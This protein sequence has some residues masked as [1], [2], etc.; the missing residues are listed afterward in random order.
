MEIGYRIPKEGAVLETD[1]MAIP[2]DAPHPA[3]AHAFIAYILDPAVAAKITDYVKYANP[4][5]AATPLV[6]AAVRTDPGIYPP[7]EV[8]R[9]LISLK[10]PN[11]QE[12]RHLNRLWT[13]I[14]ANL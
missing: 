3:A 10:T 2:R 5:L 13:R 4:N 8:Q 11:D 6:E 7:A 1:V 9:K 14:K 12:Q